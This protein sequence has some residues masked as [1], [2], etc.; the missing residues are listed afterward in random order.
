M[1]GEALIFR[2]GATAPER[3]AFGESASL[4]FLQAA[5]GGYIEAVPQF[6]TIE[7]GGAAQQGT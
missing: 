7:D 3:T 6:E 1:R 4:E 2:P 5:V